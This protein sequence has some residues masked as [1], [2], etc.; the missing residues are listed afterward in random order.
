MRSPPLRQPASECPMFT[1]SSLNRFVCSVGFAGLLAFTFVSVEAADTPGLLIKGQVLDYRRNPGTHYTIHARSTSGPAIHSLTLT[2]NLG[3]YVFEVLPGD[4]RIEVDPNEL[5]SRG[6]F[7]APFIT[8]CPSP[9][10][11]PPSGG[12]VQPPAWIIHPPGT[13]ITIMPVIITPLRPVLSAP[14]IQSEG[15]VSI[16]LTFDTTWLPLLV[17]RTYRVE[18]SENMETWSPV[19]T[20]DLITSPIIVT[21]TQLNPSRQRFFRAIMVE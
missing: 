4:W 19:L 21:E 20:T 9:A 7:C 12:S 3:N 1:P 17:V 15:T 10:E 5:I 11:C 18:S 13:V 8:I 2:D 14:E 16:L 6:F